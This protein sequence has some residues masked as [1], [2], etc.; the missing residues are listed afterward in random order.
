[1]KFSKSI[2]AVDSHTAGEATRIVV[3]GVPK[4]PGKTMPEKKQWL[5]D[6]MADMEPS[7]LGPLQKRPVAFL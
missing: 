3:G 6:N 4:I 1:M 5:E 2:H 7:V